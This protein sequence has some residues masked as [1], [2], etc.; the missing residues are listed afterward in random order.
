[1]AELVSGERLE[2]F[3]WDTIDDE[4]HGVPARP[5]EH[6]K[7]LLFLLGLIGGNAGVV[8]REAMDRPITR[9]VVT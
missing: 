5:P 3:D 6:V 1:M 8:A 7:G 2:L 4:A 9:H